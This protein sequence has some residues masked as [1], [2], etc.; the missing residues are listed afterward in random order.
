MFTRYYFHVIMYLTNANN[1]NFK[2]GE[3]KMKKNESNMTNKEM[4]KTFNELTIVLTSLND[5]NIPNK[6]K[7]FGTKVEGTRR[8]DALRKTVGELKSKCKIRRK[9][10]VLAI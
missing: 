4:V 2:Q 3:N 5:S 1:A 9:Q 8:I 6:V 7:R 10:P